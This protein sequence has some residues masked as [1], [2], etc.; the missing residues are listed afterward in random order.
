MRNRFAAAAIAALV[1]GVASPP[2]ANGQTVCKTV[3]LGGPAG[4]C[5]QRCGEIMGTPPRERVARWWTPWLFFGDPATPSRIASCKAT[6]DATFWGS[7]R[8]TICGPAATPRRASRPAMSP[9]SPG[10]LAP[11]PTFPQQPPSQLGPPF[12]STGGGSR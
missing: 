11:V 7:C 3:H 1:L 6:S 2:G 5:R 12:G 9:F 4:E 10:L 8:I